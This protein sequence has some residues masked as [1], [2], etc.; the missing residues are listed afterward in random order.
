MERSGQRSAVS[1]CIFGPIVPLKGFVSLCNIS[2]LIPLWKTREPS[3]R[4]N[5]ILFE[6]K[7]KNKW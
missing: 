1:I 6:N 5:I 3:L 2:K 7:Y 4:E